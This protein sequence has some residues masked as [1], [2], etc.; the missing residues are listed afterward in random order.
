MC[1]IGG[2]GRHIGQQSTD[3]SVNYQSI[4]DRQSTDSRRIVNHPSPMVKFTL[5]L[6]F[7]WA[8]QVLHSEYSDLYV[9]ASNSLSKPFKKGTNC[10]LIVGWNNWEED[11]QEMFSPSKVC[12]VISRPAFWIKITWPFKKNYAFLMILEIYLLFLILRYFLFGFFKHHI[13]YFQI[14]RNF[15]WFSLGDNSRE[16]RITS[17]CNRYQI[18]LQNFLQNLYSIW[19]PM[20]S[21][22][23]AD[24]GNNNKYYHWKVNLSL[25]FCFN[26]RFCRMSM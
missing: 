12:K 23:S 19:F 3:I 2:L 18:F 17:R 13:S 20:H 8:W 26:T 24:Y 10:I 4:V 15:W 21:H 9:K 22:I 1:T 14:N 16:W 25:Y 6:L 11:W 7:V 5:V